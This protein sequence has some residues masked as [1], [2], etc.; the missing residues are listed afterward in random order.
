MDQSVGWLSGRRVRE[1]RQREECDKVTRRR[2]VR[3]RNYSQASKAKVK[4]EILAARLLGFVVSR[5]IFR[6]FDGTPQP[7]RKG[8]FGWLE[9]LL[10]SRLEIEREQARAERERERD[11]D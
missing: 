1:T 5:C 8:G 10:K 2:V 6:Y 3:S 4:S 9:R 11:R 7:T